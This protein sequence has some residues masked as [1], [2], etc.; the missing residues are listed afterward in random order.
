MLLRKQVCRGLLLSTVLLSACAST[1]NPLSLETRDQFFVQSSTITWALT[2]K[3]QEVEN[4]KDATDDGTR[5]TGRQE[6]HEKLSLALDNEFAN[7]PSGPNPIDFDVAIKKY[8]RAGSISQHVLGTD[9]NKLI[10]DVTVKNA[11]SGAELAVYED[12]VGFRSGS[13]GIL[14]AVVDAA[15]EPDIPGIMAQS[16]AQQLRKRFDSKK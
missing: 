15:S 8:D 13:F 6:L 10:A 3:E 12:V 4:K 11:A 7:S 2:E 1:P 14:G 9:H 5:A 16:F